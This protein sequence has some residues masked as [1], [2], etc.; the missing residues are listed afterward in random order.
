MWGGLILLGWSCATVCQR[1]CRGGRGAIADS[2][3]GFYPTLPAMLNHHVAVCFLN[4]FEG[5]AEFIVIH[6]LLCSRVYY[7]RSFVLNSATPAATPSTSS[8]RRRVVNT[9][10]VYVGSSHLSA[11]APRRPGSSA[12]APRCP[13]WWALGTSSHSAS[14][15]EH[16]PQMWFMVES[17]VFGCILC[18]ENVST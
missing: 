3:F 4:C 6:S 1:G 8:L 15:S 11:F 10:L 7:R 9:V 5:G 18:L 13:L 16:K 12:L 14:A 2:R 17:I